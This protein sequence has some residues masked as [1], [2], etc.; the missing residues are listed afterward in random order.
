MSRQEDFR[1]PEGVKVFHNLEDALEAYKT[2]HVFVLGGG[3]IYRLA[4]PKADRLEITNV[5]GKHEGDTFFPEIDPGVWK[6]TTHS[7]T[8]TH[9]FASYE[10]I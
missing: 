6:K 8:D 2:E 9:E 7:S 5:K 4:F 10:R 1:A 3:E